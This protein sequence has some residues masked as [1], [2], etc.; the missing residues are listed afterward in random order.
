MV[1]GSV[2]SITWKCDGNPTGV[3][4]VGVNGIRAMVAGTRCGNRLAAVLCED[5][6]LDAPFRDIIAG[7]SRAQGCFEGLATAA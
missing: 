2:T 5:I 4:I 7:A 6:L 3:V 1:L